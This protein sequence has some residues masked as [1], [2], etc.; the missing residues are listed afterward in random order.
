[1]VERRGDTFSFLDALCLA[2]ADKITI[3]RAQKS[4]SAIEMLI[5]V[6]IAFRKFLIGR[7][8]MKRANKNT[9]AVSKKS[10]DTLI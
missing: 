5:V 1:M 6:V 7:S 2:P 3:A 10:G 8:I 9:E 4:E